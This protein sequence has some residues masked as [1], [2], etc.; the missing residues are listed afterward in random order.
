MA[1]VSNSYT[2][3][4]STTTY[5]F[6]FP[7]LNTADVKVK[8]NGT[9]QNTT[10]Y[11]LP[12]ATTL[13][14]NTAPSNGS[15]ILIFRDTDNDAK[16]ATFY[17]GS[18]IKAEDLN[19]DFDQILYTA[20]EVDAFA[21]STL[22]DDAMQGDLDIGNYKIT[23]LGT[24]TAGTD[25][26]N[27]TYVDTNTWDTGAETY[28]SSETW[29]GNNTTIATSGAIDARIDSKVDT[30]MEGDVLAGT[31][32]SKSAS[33][34]QVTINH[35]VT[36]ANSTVNNSNGNVL[37][38]ITVTAQGHVTSVGSTDLDG[39][40]YT[41]TELD[42]GQLDNRYYT[43][44][45]VDANFYKLGSVGEITS[46]ETWSAAD[47]K[48]ATT[49]AIDARITDL[50]DDV[51]GFVA[52]DN[53]QAFP[54]ANPDINNSDG[55]IVSIKA[56]G[57]NLVSNGSGEVTITNGTVGNSTVTIV[58]LANST[59]YAYGYGM[60]VG[61]TP[62]LHRYIFHR[63][64]PK[65]TE[66]TT[67][68][69]NITNINAVANNETNIN[70][71]NSNATNINT[72]AGN[73]SN[74][75]TVAGISSNVTSVAGNE[76]NINAV[77]SNSSNINTVA[78]AISNVNTT[79]GS[80]A[81][82]NTV[83]TNISSVND[84]SDLY[85]ISSSD[86]TSHLHTGDLVFNTTSNE[87][88][89]YNGSAWQGGVTATGNLLSK[90]GGEMTG[91]IT[92]SGSQTVDG[93]D[94]SADGTK[95][96]GIA[97][98]AEANVQSDWNATSG[99]AVILN[100]PTSFG[101]TTWT[102]DTNSVWSETSYNL[103]TATAGNSGVGIN[104]ISLG[105]QSGYANTANSRYNIRIGYQAGYTN[106]SW[107]S[108]EIAI[109]YHAGKF[110]SGYSNTF[111]GKESGTGTSG[112]STGYNSTAFG[113]GTLKSLT[114][115][116]DNTAVGMNAGTA[117][118]TG[119]DNTLIGYKAG[120]TLTTG[121][122]NICLG[123]ESAP[124]SNTVDHEATIGDSALTKFRIPGINFV[125][126][127]NG[128]TPTTG[129]V[130]TADGSG[131]GYWAAAASGVSSDAQGNTVGGTNAL[132]NPSGTSPE[133][134]TMFG[135]NA[136]YGIQT[137]DKNTGFGYEVLK[138]GY[139][140]GT[141]IVAIGYQAMADAG[142]ASYNTAVG[143]S[144]LTDLTTATYCTAVGRQ[145]GYVTST[146][147]YNAFYGS[148]SGYANTT[149]ESN[150]FIGYNAGNAVTTGN[151][152]TLIGSKAGE[153]LENVDY[154]TFIGY[155]AG[156]LGAACSNNV[157][158]G[159]E[160]G[161]TAS[162]SGTR[163][164]SG[165][166]V[167]GTQG[168]RNIQE[169]GSNI[170][171]GLRAADNMKNGNQNY[172]IGEYAGDHANN[173]QK[174]IFIGRKAGDWCE[175]SNYNIG[176]GDEANNYSTGD[177]NIG[178]GRRALYVTA[179]TGTDNIGI[180]QLAGQNIS[181]ATYS[182]AIGKGAMGL[183]TVTG[184]ENIAIGYQTGEDLTSGNNN[185]LIGREAGANLTSGAYNICMGRRAAYSSGIGSNNV[186][187]GYSA[188]YNLHTG[189][190]NVGIGD[191]ALYGGA[192]DTF[193]GSNNIALG[194][195]SL[196]DV[197]GAIGNVCLGYTAGANITNG[198]YNIAIGF[199]AGDNYT[200][201]ENNIAIGRESMSQGTDA[202]KNNVCI[203]YQ[204]GYY[205]SDGGNGGDNGKNNTFVGTN[206]GTAVTTGHNNLLLGFNAGYSANPAG[207]VDTGSDI[208][209]LGDN[210]I[211]DFYCADTSISSSDKRDKTDVT[212]FTHGLKWVEQ[213]KPITYRWDK[214]TWYH[215]YNEDGTV[216]T[217]GTPDS[218]KKRARQHIGFL[219]QDV[220]AIEQAD[221]FASKK[222][223][224]LVVNLNEDDTAYGLKYERLVPVL[225]NAI[226]ELSAK[227][228]A[229]EAK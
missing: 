43:E 173:A 67:V 10:S 5:S 195:Q 22:G 189:T 200:T 38:D 147:S 42:G 156:L 211:S 158:I 51:G 28:T 23:N 71:V 218:S 50:V 162:Q 229:L 186:I 15:T 224:M 153:S 73:N 138:N 55:T 29:T 3:N 155:K 191:Q 149:G 120:N 113:F 129:Q 202:P 169:A 94:V 12:T 44:T 106:T 82:V 41:E 217:E 93:R 64:T 96:D 104:N 47:N 182:I 101:G 77:N 107:A 228:K 221:G 219:A 36:G 14:F 159:K 78:G 62:T 125:L 209:V 18:A 91:N 142:D 179:T 32:L 137:A 115:G 122:N 30:A 68:A 188:G 133:H 117:V 11:T 187:L 92:F 108:G 223:D 21:F 130:L 204:T 152:N 58:G 39:R 215:E 192:S 40:Y 184:D 170:A 31:D 151:Y 75:T 197:Q 150:T 140:S 220:L 45:E 132:G 1:V 175:N 181:S 27:K 131:E 6:T 168:M 63:L 121:R 163:S 161:F 76:T 118:T 174:C 90:S 89:V 119:Y 124:S 56:L 222:D 7:Y 214:R 33:S 227:V 145:A 185:Y 37:Q 85:R 171:I 144:A 183:G 24:P 54:N 46:G 83:A 99:D 225:V 87:L 110:N 8:V 177:D 79:A 95:L 139:V 134:N 20:Q 61:T 203:G 165:N 114:S 74:V 80:I 59:T 19:N 167:I 26:V 34:G 216:K 57:N 128:G 141:E 103:H 154:N 35:N 53:E 100:K 65:A 88:R 178:I 166:V 13:Q 135:S 112:S 180:G 123:Y 208:V 193:T 143:S 86:P 102:T 205:I 66:V 160:A 109:G 196:Y 60:L 70:A 190:H 146:G 207:Y 25:G 48:I 98:G 172:C 84:F 116:Y 176:I 127:D 81:N 49:A 72:V 126:K 210:S 198:N 136:G 52:I 201:G 97:A 213:L 199:V 164:G 148:G 69:G 17:P 105:Y 226:K 16:K 9:T 4:G 212:D 206:A 194:N 157:M 111:V 2:G